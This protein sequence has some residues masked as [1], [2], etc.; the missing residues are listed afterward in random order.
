MT[1]EEAMNKLEEMA[2]KIRQE[3]I[4][5]EEAIKCYEEGLRC[6]EICGDILKNAKQKNEVFDAKEN[7]EQRSTELMKSTR[8]LLKSI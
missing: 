1:F 4:T 6:Y 3:D 5:L 2:G 7:S 8:K